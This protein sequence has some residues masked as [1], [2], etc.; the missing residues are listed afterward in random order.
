MLVC[1]SFS[2]YYV[3]NIY[4]DRTAYYDEQRGGSSSEDHA[5]QNIMSIQSM[6]NNSGNVPQPPQAQDQE[7]GEYSE[8]SWRRNS[9]KY[10]R[11]SREVPFTAEF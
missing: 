5:T 11:S 3:F 7:Q 1:V 2:D 9:D 10:K 4:L 8:K 6:L